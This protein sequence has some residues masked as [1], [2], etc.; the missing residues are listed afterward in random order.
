VTS[1]LQ[2][3]DPTDNS[4]TSQKM[5]YLPTHH[6]MRPPMTRTLDVTATESGTNGVNVSER[7]SL[8]GTS[9]RL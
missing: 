6:Q 3:L 2:K 8:S 1:E 7:L 5:S 9:T 4:T